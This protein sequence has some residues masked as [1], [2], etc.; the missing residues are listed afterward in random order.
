[1]VIPV[2]LG[3]H[4]IQPRMYKLK[5][6]KVTFQVTNKGTVDRDFQ[7]PTLETHHGHEQHLLRPGETRALEYDLKPGTHEVVCTLPGHREAGM[8]GSLEVVP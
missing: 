5:A 8:V 7:I 4:T 2:T 1:M 6:G 3:D